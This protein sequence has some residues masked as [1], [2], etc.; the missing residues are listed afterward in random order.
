MAKYTSTSIEFFLKL[1]LRDGMAYFAEVSQLSQ[2][3]RDQ[4]ESSSKPPPFDVSTWHK[5]QR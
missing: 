2:E 1:S 4:V 5:W 3:E